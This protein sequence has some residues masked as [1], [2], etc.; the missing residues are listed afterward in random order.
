MEILE[1]LIKTGGIAFYN[2]DKR[3]DADLDDFHEIV[4]YTGT[5]VL[6]KYRRLARFL[7]MTSEPYLTIKGD[8]LEEYLSDHENLYELTDFLVEIVAEQTD[9]KLR[10]INFS[11]EKINEN[12]WMVDR[13]KN[14]T[15]REEIVDII[16]VSLMMVGINEKYED[17]SYVERMFEYL[18]SG[19]QDIAYNYLKSVVR[20]YLWKDAVK[21]DI[22]CHI[23]VDIDKVA[24]NYPEIE[25]SWTRDFY[26]KRLE[27]IADWL[28]Q[29]NAFEK[30]W[31]F[32]VDI[33]TGG[34]V[35]YPGYEHPITEAG[36][37]IRIAR[38]AEDFVIGTKDQL[39]RYESFK[40]YN[41]K[42]GKNL[43]V[44]CLELF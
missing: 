16:E 26:G 11:E 19:R 30:H 18:E 3:L 32:A 22:R 42:I 39:R 31:N 36:F 6:A 13:I 15:S 5:D 28:P 27:N 21:D 10:L 29:M 4:N 38:F 44:F 25:E 34:W 40:H 24:E 17:D 35:G 41:D 37:E 8:K 23:E 12:E 20:Q 43:E 7:V 9:I 2:K 14:L 1:E 33:S